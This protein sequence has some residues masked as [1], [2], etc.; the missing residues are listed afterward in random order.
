VVHRGGAGLVSELKLEI[1]AHAGLVA[2]ASVILGRA[3][4]RRVGSFLEARRS[5]RLGAC[6]ARGFSG[7]SGTRGRWAY[8]P[9]STT[10][11]TPDGRPGKVRAVFP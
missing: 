11:K 4:V 2:V 8:T 7:T 6:G 5:P 9:F 3:A 10:R 1:A